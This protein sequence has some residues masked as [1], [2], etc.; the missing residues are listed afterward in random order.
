MKP[1]QN[2]WEKL[3]LES[4]FVLPSDLPCI[5]A[6]NATIPENDSRRIVVDSVIPEPFVG[7]VFSSSVVILLLNPGLDETN[8]PKVHAD[9]EFRD[10]LISNM[11]HKRTDYPFYFFNPVFR[12]TP[13]SQYWRGK[14]KQLREI[15]DDSTLARNLAAIE[16]FPY[17]S[18]KYGSC[19]VPSQQYSFQLV[20]DA[21][22]RKATI[23]V[24]RSKAKW[25]DSVPELRHYPNMLTLSSSQNVVLSKNNMKH[26]GE[27][28]D[29]AWELLINAIEET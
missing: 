5:N 25:E 4:P 2:P 11:K 9:P 19:T 1:P 17:K 12:D 20:K 13:G 23:V 14:T 6:F 7:D 15:F 22:Q 10:A 29:K 8:D 27:N 26:K 21:I 28:T 18:K 3:S 16:W 24:A